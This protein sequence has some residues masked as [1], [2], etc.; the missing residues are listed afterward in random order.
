MLHL[1]PHSKPTLSHGTYLW[2]PYMGVPLPEQPL[3]LNK[4][5]SLLQM[6]IERYSQATES[7]KILLM[8]LDRK[9]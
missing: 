1:N 2:S 5:V 4:L 7:V 3:T 8:L 6:Y 9:N